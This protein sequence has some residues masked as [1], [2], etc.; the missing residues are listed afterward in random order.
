MISEAALPDGWRMVRFGDIARNVK[1]TVDP[2]TSGLERYIAG[3][4]MDTDDLHLRR[5]GTIGDGYL[6]PA[7]HRRFK[8]GQILYGSRRTYLRKVVV[9][10]FDGVCANTT[11][12]IEPKGNLIEPDLLPFIMQSEGFTE[13]SIANSKGSVNPYVNWKDIASYEFALPPKDEQRRIAEIL[14]AAEEAIERF[15]ALDTALTRLK[16]AIWVEKVRK[17]KWRK[18]SL[19]EVAKISNGTTPSRKVDRYWK[20]GSIPWLPTGKV[21]ER[22]INHADE[23]ITDEALHE[24]SLAVLPAD[25]VLIAMIGQGKTR[26][27]V[28]YLA[29][30]ACIN[31]NFACAVP[32]DDI[33]NW[34]LF[35]YL[36]NSYEKLRRFSH[37]SNQGALN[38]RLLEMFPVPLPP[39]DFQQELAGL[40][41]GFDAQLEQVQKHMMRLSI[42]KKGLL[43][44]LIDQ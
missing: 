12:V 38:C 27:R 11:F 10:D 43:D 34:Y 2:E 28:A 8:A 33:D 31:Q 4:H 36:E 40:F 30:D 22:V 7:F 13:H 35:T 32:S 26:G 15:Q 21:H 18:V 19:G 3:E 41:R 5:W 14:W 42:L 23:F 37:G 9:A 20:D 39:K 44:S 1:V 16:R 24:C 17:Q 6:G 29:V 25:S